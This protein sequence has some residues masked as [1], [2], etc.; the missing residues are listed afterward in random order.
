MNLNWSRCLLVTAAAL[1]PAALQAECRATSADHAVAV[2]E[3]YT[4]E[5]CDSCPPAD[6]WL[7]ALK[8]GTPA[9]PA[10]ALA[11]HVDYWDRLG[12]RD[13]FGSAAFTQRQY[14]QSRRQHGDFVYTPQVLLQGRDFAWQRNADPTAA[15]AAVAAKRPRAAIE[16]GVESADRETIAVDL[17]VRIPEARDRAHAAVVVALTQDGLASEVKAGEN[18]GK[19]LAHD[20]VV[21]AWEP[22]L[23]LGPGGDLRRTIRFAR[24][25]DRGPLSIVALAEDTKTGEVLQALSLPLC[26][27]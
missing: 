1:S 25:T 2:V 12:W 3:L 17:T 9:A 8:V 21:R 27:P 15:M 23:V 6:R 14:E 16:L 10:V 5:G 13:R 4:S 22:N 26:A 7:S 24:P 19:R 18:A 20:R 11:F